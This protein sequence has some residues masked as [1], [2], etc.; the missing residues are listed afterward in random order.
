[1]WGVVKEVDVDNAGLA[2]FY[3]SFYNFPLFLDVEQQTYQ[4]FGSRRIALTTWNPFRLYQGMKEMGARLASKNITG[5]LVG[6]GMIQGGI[7]LFDA[8]TGELRYA[9][10]E[11]IGSEL[12]VQ[13]IRA[14]VGAIVRENSN[15]NDNKKQQSEEA[16]A[17]QEL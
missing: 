15:P 16:A 3:Q 14:A 5:N 6:E 7:L 11:E 12:P 10:D 1:M 4:A 9:F 13:D 17:E 2:E 8:S